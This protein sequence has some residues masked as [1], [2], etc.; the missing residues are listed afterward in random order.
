ML[1]IYEPYLVI[2]RSTVKFLNLQGAKASNNLII[3]A[4]AKGKDIS[5]IITNIN[6]VISIV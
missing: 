3:S 6:D 4:L 2:T 5:V 1:W